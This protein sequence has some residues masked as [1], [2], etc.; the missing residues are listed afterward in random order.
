[1]LKKIIQPKEVL[2]KHKLLAL[3]GGIEPTSEYS[4]N[5]YLEG[6]ETDKRAKRPGSI[7]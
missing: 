4:E 2:S 6:D 3:K 1:M 5:E 7:A